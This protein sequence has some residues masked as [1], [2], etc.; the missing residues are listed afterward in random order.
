MARQGIFKKKNWARVIILF[1]NSLME[2][3]EC[4]VTSSEGLFG[5]IQLLKQMCFVGDSDR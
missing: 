1:T 5:D 2:K 4:M 3:V